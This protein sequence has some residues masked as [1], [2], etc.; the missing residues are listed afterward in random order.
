MG[1]GETGSGEGCPQCGLRFMGSI[2]SGDTRLY[3]LCVSIFTVCFFMFHEFDS[4]Y[5]PCE[6]W[7]QKLSKCGQNSII[8][9]R[10]GGK[11][12]TFKRLWCFHSFLSMRP[13]RMKIVQVTTKV[14]LQDSDLWQ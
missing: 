8:K 4:I 14:V 7:Q 10:S 12:V 2:V 5:L 6:I 13:V 9:S 3:G 1:L 11:G